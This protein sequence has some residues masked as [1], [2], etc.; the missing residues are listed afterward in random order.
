MFCFVLVVSHSQ[1][2][3]TLW[4]RWKEEKISDQRGSRQVGTFQWRLC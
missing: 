1:E 2:K 4:G 3:L